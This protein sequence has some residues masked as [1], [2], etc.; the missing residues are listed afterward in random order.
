MMTKPHEVPFRVHDNDNN[1]GVRRMSKPMMEKRRRARIN[2]SLMQLK[3]IV[4]D[5]GK[6]NIQVVFSYTS[7]LILK[8]SINFIKTSSDFL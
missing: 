4:V 8:F 7:V 2:N 5:S 3:A 1:N 6:L